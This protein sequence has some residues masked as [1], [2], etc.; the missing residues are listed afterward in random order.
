MK[1][2]AG[3]RT[4]TTRSVVLSPLKKTKGERAPDSQ[5]WEP[6]GQEDSGAVKGQAHTWRAESR[7]NDHTQA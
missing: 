4:S 5:R 1:V 2:N 7:V 3:E 6:I